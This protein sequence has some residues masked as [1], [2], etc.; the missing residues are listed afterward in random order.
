MKHKIRKKSMNRKYKHL[1]AAVAGA[2][3]I[4][5]SMLPGLPVSKAFAA[6]DPPPD[7]SRSQVTKSEWYASVN[8]PLRAAKQ[9]AEDYGFNSTRDTF[10]LQWH[11]NKEASVLVKTANGATYKMRLTREHRHDWIVTNVEEV[12][13]ADVVQAGS[14]VE[15]VKDNAAAYGF[16]A[17]TDRF[18]LLSLTATKAIVQVR[19]GDRTFKVDLTRQGDSW[20]ITTIRGIGNAKY[21][22]TYTPARLY[23]PVIAS[24]ATDPADQDVLYQTDKFSGWIWHENAYPTD[25]SFS[26]F[27]QNPNIRENPVFIPDNVLDEIN[28]IDFS[29]RFVLYTHLGKV[30]SRGYGIGIEKVLQDGNNITVV[31]RTTSP[32]PDTRLSASQKYDYITLDRSILVFDSPVYITFIDHNGTIL[33]KYKITTG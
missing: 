22:A 12:S 25:M 31:V 9:Y 1:M 16:D 10:S 20:D 24:P 27:A 7:Y 6:S 28:A 3:V 11:T 17:E 19:T 33:N 13:S 26:V 18:S 29:R 23:H 15:V 21:P 32:A 30:A 8:S 2:A 14:P 5:S 4:S